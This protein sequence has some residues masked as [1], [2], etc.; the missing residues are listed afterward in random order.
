MAY[1]AGQPIK[2]LVF[3]RKWLEFISLSQMIKGDY[4]FRNLN[5]L[6]NARFMP[7]VTLIETIIF[8]YHCIH[9]STEHGLTISWDGPVPYC[10]V[11]IYDPYKRYQV[12]RYIT[13]MFVHIGVLHYIFNM[14]MQ[15]L[16]GVF[17]EMEQED[18]K[19]SFRVMAVYFSG[20]IAGSLGTSIVNPN[21]YVAGKYSKNFLRN[22][23]FQIYN[24]NELYFTI[25]FIA[26]ASGG[27]YALIAAHLSTMILNWKEDNAIKIRKVIHK[28]MT[29]IIRIIFISFLTI[30]DFA[31]AI[32]ETYVL[33]KD[34]QTGYIGHLCGAIAGI[35]V[36]F[37]ILK[38]RR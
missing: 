18:W 10:S 25:F 23:F 33:K 7:L 32:Y 14:I 27:I 28:P 6:F 21:T 15:L 19:G 37:F 13:Y 12:W 24:Y 31:I 22:N 4:N 36:G 3:G 16:V 29:K 8:T 35:L 30:H 2:G 5:I 20:V 11:L 9:L 17:L 34:S 26:G 38:N 1:S